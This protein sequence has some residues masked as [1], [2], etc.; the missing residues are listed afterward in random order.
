MKNTK[1]M[2]IQNL[3]SSKILALSRLEIFPQTIYPQN[4]DHQCQLNL[5]PQP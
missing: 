3:M 4:Q 1:H 2:S 5:I